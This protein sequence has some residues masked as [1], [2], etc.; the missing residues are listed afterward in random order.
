MLAGIACVNQVELAALDAAELPRYLGGAA[1]ALV[2]LAC[3][4][5][6]P[7]RNAAWL[8]S[9]ADRQP[10]VWATAQGLVTLP[11]ALIG[12]LF[13]AAFSDFHPLLGPRPLTFVGL[14]LAVGLLASWLGTL[15]WNAASQRL[16]T[17][18]L[19]QLIVFETLSALAYAWLLH[20]RWP[21]PLTL[22][23]A[24]LLVGGVW[25][26]LRAYRGSAASTG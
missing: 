24:A 7:I 13:F 5:W 18:L 14:M 22:L 25:L 2:A 3:W 1:L 19:G 26:G 15:C 8:R 9:H 12:L 10:R 23:G 21:A 17:G 6:Y 20:G 11:M 16:P 4:T